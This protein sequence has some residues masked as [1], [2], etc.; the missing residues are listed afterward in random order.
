MSFVAAVPDFDTLLARVLDDRL[1]KASSIH[2]PDHW[3]RVAEGGLLICAQTPAADPLLV[4]LFALFHDCQREN[5]GGDHD[6]GPRAAAYLRTLSA[7]LL[8]LEPTRIEILAEA[9]H[10]HTRGKTHPDLTIGACWDADRLDLWRAGIQP[11]P[12][13]FT[14]ETAR[15]PALL[16]RFRHQPQPPAWRELARRCRTLTAT[17]QSRPPM[18]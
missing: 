12:R 17:W 4:F 6:H 13:F 15:Q 10:D 7:N 3:R 8:R 9:C 14:T 18:V 11:H 5:D 1:H 16:H 2:G